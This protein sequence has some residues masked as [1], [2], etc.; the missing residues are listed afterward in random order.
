MMTCGD[1][2]RVTASATAI[3]AAGPELV[4]PRRSI[5]PTPDGFALL[6]VQRASLGA[7]VPFNRQPANAPRN[8]GA[9]LVCLSRL[10]VL[11]EVRRASANPRLLTHQFPKPPPQHPQLPLR[12]PLRL[13]NSHR[14]PSPI[15]QFINLPDPRK[16]RIGKVLDQKL[17]PP[18][19]LGPPPFIR[20]IWQTRESNS[21]H[22]S[23]ACDSRLRTGLPQQRRLIVLYPSE[24]ICLASF[25]LAEDAR[26]Q[27]PAAHPG[28]STEREPPTLVL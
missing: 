10:V 16:P 3:L 7:T 23:R 17:L 28:P 18:R 9:P 2:Y 13:H 19:R 24:G 4:L 5:A 12:P 6:S 27:P 22:L 1:R 21:S 14:S 11:L 20:S 25:P 8:T 15:V 26:S